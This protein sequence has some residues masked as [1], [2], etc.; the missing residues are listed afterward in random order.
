MKVKFFSLLYL[1][2]RKMW[3]IDL[4]P[5]IVIGRRQADYVTTEKMCWLEISWIVWSILIE[6]GKE[7]GG[8]S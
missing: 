1:M 3:K 4:L 7:E 5:A 2:D 6:F 8:E